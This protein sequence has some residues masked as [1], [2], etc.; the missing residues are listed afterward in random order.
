[1]NIKFVDQSPDAKEVGFIHSNGALVLLPKGSR[2]TI[3]INGS[4][5]GNYETSE[6]NYIFWRGDAE[7]I[8]YEGDKLEITL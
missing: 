4:W 7:R 2:G 3:V 6:D 8:L 5:Q 1:M